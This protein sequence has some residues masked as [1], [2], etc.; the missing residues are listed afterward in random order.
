LRLEVSRYPRGIYDCSESR[1]VKQVILRRG[2]IVVE[3][4][5]IPEAL[6]GCALVQVRFSCISSGTERANV[7]ASGESLFT[8]A[9]KQPE[10]VRKVLELISSAGLKRAVSMVRGKL[11]SGTPTGYSAAGVVVQ[12]GEGVEDLAT[13]EI[14]A[15]AGAGIANHAEYVVVPRNLLVKVP[16]DCDADLAATVALG[17]IAMQGVR[18]AEL[19]LGEYAVVIGLGVV[20]QLTCQLLLAGGCRAIGV[21]LDQS[22]VELAESL[23]VRAVNPAEGDAVK[24][25]IG[26]TGGFGAD[27]VL[28]CAATASSEP[29]Q[30]AFLMS[31]RKGRVVV[32]GDVG[33]QLER[34]TFYE[35][36]LDLR[37]STSYGPGRYDVDYEAHGV[38]YPYS[39]VRWTENR[40]MAEYLRLI[41]EKRMKV[42]EL[43][44]SVNPVEDAPAAYAG[45]S[46]PGRRPLIALLKYPEE[47]PAEVI[48]TVTVAAGD[49][50]SGAA[51]VAA[52]VGAGAFAKGMHL[53][54]IARLPKLIALRAVCDVDGANAK[55]AAKQFGAEIAT[56]SFDEVLADQSVNLVIICTPHSLHAK[57]AAAALKAGK[58][59][60]VEKPLAMDA[61][62]LEAIRETLAQL[63]HPRLMVGF[64]RR[65]SPYAVRMKEAFLRRNTPLMINYRMNAGYL[66]P[67]HW[68][69]GPDGGGRNIGEACHIYD[70]FTFLCDSEVGSA[71]A[72]SIS[73]PS[74]RY[75]RNDNFTATLKFKDGS[76]CALTYTALGNGEVPKEECDA[77]FDGK[78]LRMSDYRRLTYH[79][80]RHGEFTT[81]IQ[82]KGH[83]AELDALA[84]SIIKGGPSPI[85]EVDLLR[86]TE[87]SFQIEK[88]ITG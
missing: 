38:D 31:R 34:Q 65:F 10:K 41:A 81:Q 73:T 46:A 19:Q 51:V 33:L 79:G 50:P 25:V 44:Q 14:V 78:T 64:N 60:L 23:G 58:N 39:Y 52:V 74:D 57:Q 27:A 13:G 29:V 20:G 37:I 48:R 40:N 67:E 11:E 28:L 71:S 18:R 69:Q 26:A 61:E 7:A 9:L 3:E 83:L 87:I 72:V 35:K 30:Q 85:P 88:M 47:A 84:N 62:G 17:A 5:P 36:E 24:E 22:R 75:R 53:P 43:V 63:K 49:K 59:V 54:N 15:C 6:P 45:L 42:R 12:P 16:K 70:L 1:Q 56:T 8:K 32:V 77:Y 55:A 4:T 86:T 68:T 80:I 82:D 21:D 2:E 66:P 76:I